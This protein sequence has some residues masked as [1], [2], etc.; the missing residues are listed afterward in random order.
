MRRLTVQINDAPITSFEKI[1]ACEWKSHYQTYLYF[2][3]LSFFHKFFVHND[4]NSQSSS[5]T[6]IN[7]RG[8]ILW[9]SIFSHKKQQPKLQLYN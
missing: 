5:Y 7:V 1:N 6:A 3:K 4:V 8:R 9:V 2:Q